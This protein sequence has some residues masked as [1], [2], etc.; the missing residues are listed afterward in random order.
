MLESCPFC[1]SNA[2]YEFDSGSYGYRH[3]TV[4]VK[5]TKCFAKTDT[6]QTENWERGRGMY[7]TKDEAVKTVTKKWN[8]RAPQRNDR[9][10]KR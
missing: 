7:S 4:H 6:E 8:D 2:E 9:E 5:C 10:L 1:G 3:S